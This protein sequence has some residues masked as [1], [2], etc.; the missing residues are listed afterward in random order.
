MKKLIYLALII[1]L[2]ACGQNPSG[3]RPVGAANIG[4]SGKGGSTAR[5][6]IVDKQLYT[7]AGSNLI[8]FSLENPAEPVALHQ[9][10]VARD[11]ETM[12]PYGQSLYLGAS[13]G[14]Y[15]YDLKDQ[16]VP[17][18]LG[19]HTHQ[20]ACDPVVV[21]GDKAFVTLKAGNRC[22]G[23]ENVLEVVDIAEPERPRRISKVPMFAPTGLAIEG[24]QLFVCDGVAGLKVF[25]VTDPLD[26]KLA[27]ALIGQRCN[28]LISHQGLLIAT[29]NDGIWQYQNQQGQLELLSIL[30][31]QGKR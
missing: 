27:D 30:P 29:T 17:T 8:T 10:A 9:I 6:A 4:A 28:D 31:W 22:G 24:E 21:Q 16:D 2:Q 11:V 26:L 1:L 14:M 3:G 15:I 25:D 7:L 23:S 18:L 20:R 13:T 5:F 12:F 19:Q